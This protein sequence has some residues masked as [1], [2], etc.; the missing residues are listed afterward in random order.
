[1]PQPIEETLIV[2]DDFAEFMTTFPGI[3]RKISQRLNS[4]ADIERVSVHLDTATKFI[5]TQTVN[6]TRPFLYFVH[7]EGPGNPVSFGLGV[8]FANRTG[9]LLPISN[10]TPGNI[11]V[12]VRIVSGEIV[13]SLSSGSGLFD[14]KLLFL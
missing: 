6:E 10:Y 14:F 12:N 1:M 5:Y 4:S 9:V 13:A 3:Y 8:F 7:G 2:P 11:Q